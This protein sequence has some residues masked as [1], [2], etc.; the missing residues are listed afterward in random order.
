MRSWRQE[1]KRGK[2]EKREERFAERQGR[3]G[4]K[5][6]IRGGYLVG[7]REKH[8]VYMCLRRENPEIQ[9]LSQEL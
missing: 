1:N 4:G 7:A 6:G 2:E 5:E 3:G 9:K 8:D